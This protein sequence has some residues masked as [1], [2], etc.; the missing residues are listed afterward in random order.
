MLHSWTIE[1]RAEKWRSRQGGGGEL[2]VRAEFR[3]FVPV[4]RRRARVVRFPL[5]DLFPR[6]FLSFLPGNSATIAK[7][8]QRQSPQHLAG[9]SS[10]SPQIHLC[11]VHRSYLHFFHNLLHALLTLDIVRHFNGDESFVA[12]PSNPSEEKDIPKL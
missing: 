9:V 11:P 4:R 12:F 8:G 7:T 5:F 1:V 2:G 6:L 10:L 3:D